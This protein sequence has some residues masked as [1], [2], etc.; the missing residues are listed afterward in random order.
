MNKNC[1]VIFSKKE[2]RKKWLRINLSHQ[3][4][5]FDALVFEID[6]QYEK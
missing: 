5:R 4:I 6:I 2:F 1:I 3:T